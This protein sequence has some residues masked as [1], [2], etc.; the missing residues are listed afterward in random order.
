[1]SRNVITFIQTQFW[2][3]LRFGKKKKQQVGNC[4]VYLYRQ[5][6]TFSRIFHLYRISSL[7]GLAR[8]L[9]IEYLVRH[10]IMQ[11]AQFPAQSTFFPAQFAPKIPHNINF[12]PA[13]CQKAC[14]REVFLQ[15]LQ[16]WEKSRS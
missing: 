9:E 11:P 13:P 14:N 10:K 15:R 12:S 8:T 2:V 4:W 6:K 7:L 16:L 1:M 3:K 5:R